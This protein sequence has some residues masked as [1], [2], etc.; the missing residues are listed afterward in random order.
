MSWHSVSKYKSSSTRHVCS[1][2]GKS[3]LK[4]SVTGTSNFAILLTADP[5]PWPTSWY[6]WIHAPHTDGKV[7]SIVER[8]V[9]NAQLKLLEMYATPNAVILNKSNR[10]I[11]SSVLCLC[12]PRSTATFPN[13]SHSK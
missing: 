11:D 12:I 10:V 4:I 7:T 1:G 5:G 6:K 8:Y 3:P 13:M 2:E 9:R